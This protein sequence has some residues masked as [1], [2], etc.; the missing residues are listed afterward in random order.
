MDGVLTNF[1][2]P[3]SYAIAA[4]AGALSY[5]AYAMF[6]DR[7]LNI[8]GV[9]AATGLSAAIAQVAT[10]YQR[11]I[12]D[13]IYLGGLLGSVIALS[14]GVVGSLAYYILKS[15][16]P[17]FGPGNTLFVSGAIGSLFGTYV[18]IV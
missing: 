3:Q 9:F 13:N 14:S 18:M 1:K 6:G 11:E 7:M 8:I 5:G 17:T 2:N 10:R 12:Q 15:A 4:G 16:V